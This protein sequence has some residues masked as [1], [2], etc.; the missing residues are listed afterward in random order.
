MTGGAVG[1]GRWLIG[2]LQGTV[3][4]RAAADSVD[5]LT[6]VMILHPIACAIAFLAFALSLGA[7][8]VG[9]VLGALVAF[10]AWVLTVVV[11]AIDFSLFGVSFSRFCPIPSTKHA[12]RCNRRSKI[13]STSRTKALMRTTRSAC[14]HV[15]QPWCCCSSACSLYSLRASV[16]GRRRR[17]LALGG[18][19]T[20]PVL[21]VGWAMM[22]MRLR[23]PRRLG[24]TG[25]SDQGEGLVRPFWV[26]ERFGKIPV[27]QARCL[28][29]LL[30]V[31]A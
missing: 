13:T 24:E 22:A 29:L 30:G 17:G 27:M 31:L 14:G 25:G 8:V 11:M 10:V 15:L 9:S 7:G 20:R 21:M 6:H 4:S 16:R 2:S 26:F 12:H 23:R 3:F 1:E 28:E 19:V 18:T 5:G